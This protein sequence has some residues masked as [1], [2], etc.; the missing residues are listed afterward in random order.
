[1]ARLGLIG[2]GAFGLLIVRHLAPY[3]EIVAHDISDQ[4]GRRTK[5]FNIKMVNVE[6]VAQVDVLII[7]VPIPNIEDV[8]RRIAPHVRPNLLVLDVASVKEKPAEQLRSILPEYVEII[9]THPLFGPQSAQKS[10]YGMKIVLCPIRTRRLRLVTRFLERELGLEVVL[11]TPSE[12]DRE[13]AAI[14]GLTHLI[15]KVLVRMEP[16]PTSLRTNSFDLLMRAVNLVRHDSDEL[17]FA[18]ERENRYAAD[19]RKKFFSVANDLNALLDKV[20]P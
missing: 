8:A 1:M 12:H 15:A 11:A 18:I 10:I 5:L 4:M 6:Q 16:L 19:V 7:A 3:F 13:I 17:F 20:R 14:Q 2:V 9:C